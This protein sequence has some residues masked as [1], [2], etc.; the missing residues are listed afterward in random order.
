MSSKSCPSELL[1]DS[2]ARARDSLQTREDLSCQHPTSSKPGTTFFIGKDE[3]YIMNRKMKVKSVLRKAGNVH[4]LDL[5]VKL[6]SGTVAPLKYKAMEVDAINQ[7]FRR[8]RAMDTS[9]VRLQQTWRGRHIQANRNRKTA[10][11]RAL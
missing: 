7:V 11:W 9:H 10:I 8:K 3:A 2:S 4:V 1:K 6:P 5:F